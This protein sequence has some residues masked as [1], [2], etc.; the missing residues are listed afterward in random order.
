[1]QVWRSSV[2]ATHDFLSPQDFEQIAIQVSNDYLPSASLLLAVDSDDVP[3]GFLGM[4]HAHID[5]LF[6]AA[7]HRGK[8]IGKALMQQAQASAQA[9]NAQYLSVDVNE[10]NPHATAF[11]QRQGFTQQNRSA[12]DGDGRPYPLLHMSKPIMP[13]ARPALNMRLAPQNIL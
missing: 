12:L 5:S 11:Y 2:L 8:G 3:L 6:I 10:Q 9:L 4:N 1:M 13:A 7:E